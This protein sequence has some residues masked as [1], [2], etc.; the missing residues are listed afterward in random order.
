MLNLKAWNL[1]CVRGTTRLAVKSL[2][3]KGLVITSKFGW[4]L[5]VNITEN[6][7]V[8]AEEFRGAVSEALAEWDGLV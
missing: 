2:H 8:L 5:V 3:W 7:K 1:S 4:S 6:G